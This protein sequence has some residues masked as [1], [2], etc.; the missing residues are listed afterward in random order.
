MK[1][2]EYEDLGLFVAHNNSG[3]YLTEYKDEATTF[4]SK[5]LEPTTFAGKELKKF[6]SFKDIIDNQLCNKEP[7]Y[8]KGH[9]VIVEM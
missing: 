1:I 9:L 8:E 5:E 6:I 3:Y 7:F 2:L 4:A